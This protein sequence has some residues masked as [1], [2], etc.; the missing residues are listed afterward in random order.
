MQLVE[1]TRK[2]Y[3]RLERKY[4]RKYSFRTTKSIWGIILQYIYPINVYDN[5]LFMTQILFLTLSRVCSKYIF[6]SYF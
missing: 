4:L 3:G 5:G 1:E 2:R 6:T